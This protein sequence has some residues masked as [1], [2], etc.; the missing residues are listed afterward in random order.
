MIYKTETILLMVIYICLASFSN[1]QTIYSMKNEKMI[2]DQKNVLDA[3]KNMTSLFHNKD[4][5]GVCQVMNLMP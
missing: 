1:A 3:V 2:Q 5:E 4:I